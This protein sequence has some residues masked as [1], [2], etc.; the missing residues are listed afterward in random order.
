MSV[1]YVVCVAPQSAAV[2]LAS[3][4]P[5]Q[6]PFFSARARFAPCASLCW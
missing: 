4:F 3:R 2:L 1:Y 5:T 6:R